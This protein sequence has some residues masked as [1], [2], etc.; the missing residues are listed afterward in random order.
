MLNKKYDKVETVIGENS[1]ITGEIEVKGTVRIDG[2]VKGNIRSDWVMVGPKGKVIGD[3][4]AT[5]LAVAGSVEGNVIASNSVEI[6][7]KGQLRGDITSPKLV[8][9]EGGVFEGHSRMQ[10]GEEKVLE[11]QGKGESSG[12]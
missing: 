12:H 1:V 11:L 10:K 2:T 8:I 3:I 7:S 9:I 6:K 5:G 4:S